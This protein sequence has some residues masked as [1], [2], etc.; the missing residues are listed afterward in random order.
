MIKKHPHKISFVKWFRWYTI[1]C[2][3][4]II[5]LS[6]FIYSNKV[7]TIETTSA[8]SLIES[9]IPSDAKYQG[10]K[11]NQVNGTTSLYYDYNNTIHTVELSHPE[12]SSTREINWNE[13]T[14]IKFN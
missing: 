4:M 5:I 11:K 6:I 3:S 12:N 10:Y 8:Y 14:H 13:V 1:I 9:E 2:I 7:E